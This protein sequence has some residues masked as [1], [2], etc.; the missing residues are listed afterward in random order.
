MGP[1]GNQ[2]VVLSTPL[3]SLNNWDLTTSVP[4]NL[5]ANCTFCFVTQQA[6]YHQVVLENNNTSHSHVLEPG[7]VSSAYIAFLFFSW[8]VKFTACAMPSV[9]ATL[10]TQNRSWR[11]TDGLV[12]DTV[13]TH[14]QRK[15]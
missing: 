5:L 3:T 12:T 9:S 13:E 7:R 2:A 14:G 8:K 15:R 6:C 4:I 1:V 10:T 11:Q